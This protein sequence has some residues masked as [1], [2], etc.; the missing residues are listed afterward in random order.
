MAAMWWGSREKTGSSRCCDDQLGEKIVVT[1][2]TMLVLGALPA[3]LVRYMC[4][5]H[6]VNLEVVDVFVSMNDAW[7]L[8]DRIWSRSS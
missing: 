8:D 6:K 5:R 1:T 4:S 7:A 3:V 2:A